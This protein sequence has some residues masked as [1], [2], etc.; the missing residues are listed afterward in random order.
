M[1]LFA[2]LVTLGCLFS[3]AACSP[4]LNIDKAEE[5]LRAKEYEVEIERDPSFE[6][7][8]GLVEKSLYAERNEDW[9]EI[10]EFTNKKTAK[11]YYQTKKNTYEAEIQV[12]EDC[13][14]YYE[15]ILAE[16]DDDLDSNK[17]DELEDLV[18]GFED[19][20]EKY[21]E[22]MEAFGING[23]YVW[24]ANDIDVIEDAAQ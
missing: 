13:V 9:I 22:K 20:I 7:I 24:E 14:T 6:G 11:L 4:K 16:Y 10:Y 12:L 3:I 18:K 5:A 1:K 17:I 21:Q 19:E 23:K 2:G 8:D 15:H